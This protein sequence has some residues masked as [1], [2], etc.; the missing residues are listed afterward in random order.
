MILVVRAT[1]GPASA[2]SAAL[3]L[4]TAACAT[5]GCSRPIDPLRVDGIRLTVTNTSPERWRDLS[6]WVNTHY[7]ATVPGLEA[8]ARLDAPLDRFVGPYGRVFDPRREAVRG[9][10]LT[11]TTASGQAVTLTWGEGRTWRGTLDR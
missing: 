7:R 5:G 9:V 10:E 8:G 2:V 6:I 4:V 11:A 3:V 1:C